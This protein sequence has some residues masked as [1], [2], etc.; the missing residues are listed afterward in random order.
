MDS[1]NTA[2]D[3]DDSW[4]AYISDTEPCLVQDVLITPVCL[5]SLTC[6]LGG[7]CLIIGSPESLPS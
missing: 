3:N 1:R 7:P 5:N 4:F 6:L 2:N